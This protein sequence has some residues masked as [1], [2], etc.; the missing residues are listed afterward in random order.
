MSLRW[1]HT[2]HRISASILHGAYNYIRPTKRSRTTTTTLGSSREAYFLPLARLSR[3]SRRHKPP[4]WRTWQHRRVQQV[5]DHEQR[6]L[7]TLCS[8][9]TISA[10]LR[11]PKGGSQR[12]PRAWESQ[13]QRQ[14]RAFPTSS[15]SPH[16]RRPALVLV[17]PSSTST[18]RVM[19]HALPQ[20]RPSHPVPLLSHRARPP[21]CPP[22]P[23]AP[24]DERLR[25]MLSAPY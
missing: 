13:R 9:Q 25:P 23:S 24:P 14:R 19:V 12:P 15:P 5:R 10:P 6:P 20:T 8:L 3:H 18:N 1:Q 17:R 7:A 11:P 16:H 22:H 2:G 4:S 21:H